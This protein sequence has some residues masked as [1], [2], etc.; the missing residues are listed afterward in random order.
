MEALGD[1]SQFMRSVEDVARA[2]LH[3]KKIVGLTVQT[4][5]A[6]NRAQCKNATRTQP[7]GDIEN[8]VY[9]GKV[10]VAE[11]QHTTPGG[12]ISRDCIDQL[13]FEQI[14]RKGVMDEWCNSDRAVDS[15]FLDVDTQKPV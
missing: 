7:P 13:A 8:G 2:L 5:R 14:H 3:D 6:G 10:S 15:T 4:R 12:N 11:W 1:D 9:V